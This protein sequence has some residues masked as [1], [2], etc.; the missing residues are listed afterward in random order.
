[1]K[2][3]VLLELLLDLKHGLIKMFDEH[4]RAANSKRFSLGFPTCQ[5]CLSIHFS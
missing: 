1:M 3:Y 4:K 5:L 2:E